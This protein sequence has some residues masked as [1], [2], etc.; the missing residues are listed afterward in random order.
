MKISIRHLIVCILALA[1][2]L[3]YPVAA[4]GEQRPVLDDRVVAGGTFSLGAGETLDGSL[5]VLGGVVLLEEGS[6]ITG[7]V[8][9][10]GGTVTLRGTL[11][12]SLA[13][14]GGVVRLEESVVILGD[15]FAPVSV[16]TRADGAV[17]H[18]EIVTEFP[19]LRL[20]AP[21]PPAVPDVPGVPAPPGIPNPAE[22]LSLVFSPVV[23]AFWF[24]LKTVMFAALAVLVSVF[25]PQHIGRTRRALVSQPTVSGGLGALVLLAMLPVTLLLGLT[26]FLLPVA[27]L[28]VVLAGLACL[29]GWIAMGEEVGR[30][31]G[32]AF[33]QEWSA[34]AQVGIGT[35][36][37][38]FVAGSLGSIFWGV[39]GA[40][41]TAVLAAIGLGGVLL[42]RFGTREF[43]PAAGGGVSATAES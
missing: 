14:F 21:A 38:T 28:L 25:L 18:G 42:S 6:L 36:L 31:V 37:L 11:Q 23:Q 15:L 12:G 7:D 43:Q 41:V 3:P 22:S 17:V 24:L 13:A 29:F 39:A 32:A 26:I 16:V 35:F 2:L 8:L 10:V 33:Q 40:L 5:L 34:A 20:D 1:L 19:A 30:R 9:V 27:F 4:A